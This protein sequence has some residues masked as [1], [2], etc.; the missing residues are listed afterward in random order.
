MIPAMDLAAHHREML[1]SSFGPLRRQAEAAIALFDD[2]ATIPFVARY[3]K[4]RTGGLTETQLKE[5]KDRLDLY[6]ELCR[7]KATILETIREQGK[8]T[9]DLERAITACLDKHRLEEL[10]LPYKP[11]RRTRAQVAR[12]A[13]YE[14]LADRI[15]AHQPAN[16]DAAAMAGARDIIAERIADH[17]AARDWVRDYTSKHGTLVSKKKRGF[18][19]DA[20]LFELYLDFREPLGRLA[21]HRILAIWRGER[22]GVL[23]V[24]IDVPADPVVAQLDRTFNR[25]NSPHRDFFR[26]AIGDAY[27]RLLASSIETEIRS[28]LWE[29]AE[30]ESIR[31]FAEN[32]R[33]LLLAPP[34]R[35]EAILAIDPGLRTGCKVAVIDASGRFVA[36]TVIHPDRSD[37]GA[38]LSRL[39]SAH[40]VKKI[41][42][43]NGT[44]SREAQEFVRR[45]KLDVTTVAVSEAG[46]SVY[47][48]SD[49][50]V[51]E[52]PEL[53]VTVRGAIS[54]GRR[55][56]DPLAELVKIDPKAIGVGQY[57]HDVDQEKLKRE[58][59]HVVE[60]CVTSVGVDVNT[61][62]VELLGYVSG[63]TRPA[64]ESLV[65][66]RPFKSRDELRRVPRLG[67]KGF[68]QAAGFLRLHG[69]NPLDAS[70]VHPESYHVVERIAR[71][72]E[73][74][75]AQL[76]GAPLDM[77]PDEFVD[78][79]TGLPTIVDIF[80]ELKRPGR[81]PRKEFATV[82][83]SE[84]ITELSHVKAGMTLEGVVTNVT[85]FGAFVDVGVHQ[86]GLVHVSEIADRFVRSPAEVVH[87]GQVVRV[88]VLT[89]DLARRRIGLS[90]RGA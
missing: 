31:V 68:E 71:R 36:N 87:V 38:T 54:I 61:A 17:A 73:R 18:D 13:G 12:E 16:G 80:E 74:P 35:G 15:W 56:Q 29:R 41:A 79:R 19:G 81:D 57:Q 77:K 89:V 10:Y 72:L 47:S 11:K 34:V 1:L 65:K 28:R 51:R 50:A 27:E 9:P 69:A 37:A 23:S 45:A 46:A 4:E 64:A 86:D 70:A 7:R 43:G 25:P 21:P 60:S 58:L 90:M 40:G 76:V 67:A 59:D 39:V 26:D 44:G 42:I 20:S 82:A 75:V 84:T 32:L 5:I 52:F 66:H 63:V 49:T 6:D 14:P 2:D 48:A 55:L 83:F 8:L 22:D 78:E 88:K 53:D 62:S 3:R 85:D 33:H 24:S 30:Q